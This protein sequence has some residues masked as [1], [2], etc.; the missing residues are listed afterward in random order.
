LPTTPNREGLLD[1]KAIEFEERHPMLLHQLVVAVAFLTYLWDR[2]D[3]VWRFIKD[4]A[5]NR[6]L[7]HT[8]F[9]IAT[10]L[11]GGA[12][13]ICTRARVYGAA[14]IGGR[15]SGSFHSARNWR[16]FG[17]FLY[18]IGLAS[19]LPL[20]GFVIL[21]VGEAIRILRLMRSKDELSSAGV[22]LV[23][24]KS[25]W[26]EASQ[27]EALKWGI[28]LAMIAF[29]ITLSDRVADILIGTAWLLGLL[30]L[31]TSSWHSQ[32]SGEI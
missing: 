12:A 25:R 13:V 14:P 23:E 24:T 27:R 4:N 29:T 9:A 17:D 16:Y 10:L 6:V 2:D 22:R 8:L 30:L 15:R 26:W 11:V 20:A 7:E 28:F 3:V 32:A 31:K 5:A 1:V 21:V 19:L 18:A